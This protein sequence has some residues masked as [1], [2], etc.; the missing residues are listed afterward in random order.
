MVGTTEISL[1]V[2]NSRKIDSSD[3]LEQSLNMSY[4]STSSKIT[5]SIDLNEKLSSI[6]NKLEKLYQNVRDILYVTLQ[7]SLDVVADNC[8]IWKL[9]VNTQ[10]QNL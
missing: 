3:N 4:Q 7:Q 10:K 1:H 6:V 8:S 9:V 2:A 5:L